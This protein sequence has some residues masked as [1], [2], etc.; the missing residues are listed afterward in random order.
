MIDSAAKQKERQIVQDLELYF[1]QDDEN[2]YHYT[3]MDRN[4]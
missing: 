1:V 3:V 4:M 2:R